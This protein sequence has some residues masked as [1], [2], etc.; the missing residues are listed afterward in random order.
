MAIVWLA[1]IVV[2]LIGALVALDM[3]RF[4]L[5]KHKAENPQAGLTDA[6][7]I[8][9]IQGGKT[10]YKRPSGQINK[11]ADYAFDLRPGSHDMNMFLAVMEKA[12]AEHEAE[13]NAAKLASLESMKAIAKSEAGE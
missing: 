7:G 11:V 12:K 4:A 13:L 5:A 2:C 3:G 8:L 1:L 6:G 9:Y 10:Y